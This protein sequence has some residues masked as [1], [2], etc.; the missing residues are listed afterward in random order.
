MSVA[1]S[2]QAI[3]ESCKLLDDDQLMAFYDMCVQVGTEKKN[4]LL[5]TTFGQ[6][7]ALA[8]PVGMTGEKLI[9]QYHYY[10][11]NGEINQTDRLLVAKYKNPFTGETW[12]G[13]GKTPKW[14]VELIEQG[15]SKEDFLI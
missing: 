2:S 5:I 4:E 8:E 6:I 13:R 1:L 7:D 3:E 15:K 14:M 10:I 11:Q 9:E 12:T